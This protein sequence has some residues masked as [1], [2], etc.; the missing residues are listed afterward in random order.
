MRNVNE[1]F[2]RVP[3]RLPSHFQRAHV[4][5]GRRDEASAAGRRRTRG[6]RAT[7]GMIGSIV[8]L[9]LYSGPS[10]YIIRRIAPPAVI[11]IFELQLKI[12]IHC[13]CPAICSNRVACI[14]PLGH[15]RT[16]RYALWN[17]FHLISGAKIT[18]GNKMEN[19]RSRRPDI[20]EVP[21]ATHSR[22]G[23]TH[24]FNRTVQNESRTVRCVRDVQ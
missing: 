9:L 19:G 4:V 16:E 17:I 13:S 24:I 6:P 10:Y 15:T 12:C 5:I 11:R 2:H 21:Q 8:I 22:T 7:K 14:R 3:L 23:Y 20:T 18:A 1:F